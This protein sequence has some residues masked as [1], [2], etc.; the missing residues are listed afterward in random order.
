M[1]VI[2]ENSNGFVTAFVLVLM[3]VMTLMV[4][5]VSRVSV[6]DL[7]ISRNESESKIDFYVAEGGNNR[8]AKE[9]ARGGYSP[10][11]IYEPETIATERS[12]GIPRPSTHHVAGKTYTFT[13]QYKG[14]FVPPRGFSAI[15]FSR[16]DYEITTR[17]NEQCVVSRYGI[18]GP[19]ALDKK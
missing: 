13:V 4:V 7:W 10:A 8:E 2:G 5:C 15:D 1:T 17:C 9:L 6:A 3:V 19:K 18:I 12:A 16:Y 11:D 14:V